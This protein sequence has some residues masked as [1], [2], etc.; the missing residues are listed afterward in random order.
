MAQANCVEIQ[1]NS[2][3]LSQFELNKF[4]E[5]DEKFGRAQLRYSTGHAWFQ[6]KSG[7]KI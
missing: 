7:F 5:F 6:D 3:Q 4:G 2:T 1:L